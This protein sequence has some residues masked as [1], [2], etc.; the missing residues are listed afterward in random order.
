MQSEEKAAYCAAF[1]CFLWRMTLELS[2]R[3]AAVAALV[4]QGTRLADV[5]TDHAYLPVWLILNRRINSAIAA[6]IRS[7]PLDHARRTAE[8]FGLTDR[9]DLRLCD[10]LESI[11][12]RECDTITIAGMGGETMAGVLSRAGWTREG[13]RL[14]LQPQSTQDVLRRFLAD[15]GWCIC[16]EQVVREGERWYPILLVEGGEMAPLSPGEAMA[17]RPDTWVEQPERQGYLAWLLKRTQTQL[18]GLSKS[19]KAEDS[20]RKKAL[21]KAEAFLLAHLD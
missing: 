5:G 14:I 12:A 7:G 21:E 15:H 1:S 2:P 8:E 3:L 6:D 20:E 11:S 19:A 17:G 9:L 16:S 10:G 4:P 13:K 18:V